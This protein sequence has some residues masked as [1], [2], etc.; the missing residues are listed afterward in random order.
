[1]LS[2]LSPRPS[3]EI[4][5]E[6]RL[7]R[8]VHISRY[9]DKVPETRLE[10][11]VL[12]VPKTFPDPPLNVNPAYLVRGNIPTWIPLPGDVAC[13]GIGL[14]Q[15]CREGHRWYVQGS[16][17][18]PGCARDH[19]RFVMEESYR[20]VKA[21]KKASDS[22]LRGRQYTVVVRPMEGYVGREEEDLEA[23]LKDA[24]W[25]MIAHGLSGGFVT[26]HYAGKKAPGVYAPHGHGL[27]P[28]WTTRYTPG[29]VVDLKAD[30][31]S[32]TMKGQQYLRE[33]KLRL[34]AMSPHARREALAALGRLKGS[35]IHFVK[36]R[37]KGG[38]WSNVFK[39]VSDELNHCIRRPGKHAVR[40]FGA[41][42]YNKRQEWPETVDL[43]PLQKQYETA[44]RRRCP[45]DNTPM[46]EVSASAPRKGGGRPDK[47]VMDRVHKWLEGDY[48]VIEPPAIDARSQ[49]VMDRAGGRPEW[50]TWD[51]GY[52]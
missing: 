15:E 33:V 23:F 28:L 30:P 9:K 6:D 3:P 50:S 29:P 27:G 13:K 44:H 41:L 5:V 43:G 46:M 47:R 51:D 35:Y 26:P 10:N 48:L 34:Y 42:A 8:D 19:S 14:V 21:L 40:W 12:Q 49:A 11:E 16:C 1:M 37:G 24:R 38:L 36:V 7:R 20:I 18:L 52:E 2:G 45:I 22:G 4:P 32:L 39:A 31:K 25:A 17:R